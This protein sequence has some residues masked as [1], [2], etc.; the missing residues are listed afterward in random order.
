MT[1]Q[2]DILG[3][4]VAPQQTATTAV[5]AT[6]ETA[7]VDVNAMFKD[8]LSAI[9]NDDTG[10]Q[11]YA[12]VQDAL[13]G[14]AHAQ[15]HIKTLEQENVDLQ[16]RLAAAESL[17]AEQT[18][19]AA[20][21]IQQEVYQQPGVS[22]E[23]VYSMV[24]DIEQSKVHESNRTSVKD[25]LISHCNG[26]AVKA[27]TLINERL[28]KLNMSRDSLNR[29]ATTSPEAVYELLGLSSKGTTS[30]YSGGTINTDAVEMHTKKDVPQARA[31][32]I[33]ATGNHLVSAWRDAVADVNNQ[34]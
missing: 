13:A 25:T 27:D 21:T 20:S 28:Q 19:H 4:V 2:S 8:Q 34:S 1:D 30:S 12:S 24:K 26:D 5:T 16:N 32:P 29:L 9:K 22:K 33:G 10:L 7:P 17:R 15:G 6:T 31:L 14:T 18:A 3:E 11:K 23:D